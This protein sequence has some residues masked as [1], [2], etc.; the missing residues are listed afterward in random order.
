MQCTLFISLPLLFHN[1]EDLLDVDQQEE[2]MRCRG[3]SSSSAV[4]KKVRK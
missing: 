4:W 1:W 2:K 3:S